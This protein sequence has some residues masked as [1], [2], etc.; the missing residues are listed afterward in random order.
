LAKPEPSASRKS[1]R[2]SPVS[3]TSSRIVR[4]GHPANPKRACESIEEVGRRGGDA[5]QIIISL[6]VEVDLVRR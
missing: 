5:E 4:S 1:A 6:G 3:V 2:G